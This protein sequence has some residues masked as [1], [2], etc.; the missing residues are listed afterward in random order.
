MEGGKL[1]PRFP[2]NTRKPKCLCTTRGQIVGLSSKIRYMMLLH[3]SRSTLE[4]MQYWCM[5]GMI[6][7]KG[8]LGRNMLLESLTWLKI[9]TL[10]TWITRSSEFQTSILDPTCDGKMNEKTA[11]FFMSHHSWFAC[12]RELSMSLSCWLITVVQEH[13]NV[14]KRGGMQRLSA[15]TTSVVAVFLWSSGVAFWLWSY[16][17]L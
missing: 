6:Q 11:M 2:N 16:S 3:T 10:V 15:P 14:S 4:V 1:P 13:E 8:F 12:Q 17:R 7:L 9:S 5:L